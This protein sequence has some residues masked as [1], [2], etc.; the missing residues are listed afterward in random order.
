MLTLA[1]T[2]DANVFIAA[3]S[4]ADVFHVDSDAFLKR[5][6]H[7]GLQLQ[8]PTLLLPETASGIIRPTG[9]IIAAQITV[10]SV[11]TFPG[12]SLVNLTEQRAQA[13]TQIAL[14]HHLRGADSI[15]VAVAQE[16]GTTLITWDNE[17]LTRGANAVTV[18]TPDDW[19]AANPV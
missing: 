6:R 1:L 18:M 8:C 7:S 17:A 10:D 9:N 3:S 13:A 16:F 19:L 11:E 5:V 15:Y 14:R 12:M 4:L 2:I